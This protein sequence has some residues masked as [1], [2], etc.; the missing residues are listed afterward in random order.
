MQRAILRFCVLLIGTMLFVL[1]GAFSVA[2]QEPARMQQGAIASFAPVVEKV[3]PS[4][5]TV[6]TT[7]TVS[8]GLAPFPFSDDALRQ[9]FGG[10][11]PRQGKQ[12]L[13][14][15]G[16][17][18]IVSPDGYIL[19]ANH[20]VS[21]AEEIMVGLGTEL[22][23]YKAKK[24]GTDPGTDVALLK[25]DEKNLPAIA[26][27]DSEKARAGDI[28]LAIGNPFG[29][30][31]TVTMGIIS[32]VG[33][34]GMGIVDYENFIQTDAAINMGNSGGALVDT[35]G[36]L[37]GIN[38]A[39]FTRTG[40]S[41]GVGFA[42]PANLARDVM[43]SLREKGRVVR[44]Y[45]GTSV[46]TLTPELAEA[47]KLKGELTGALVGEVVPKSPSEKAGM[48]TGDVITSV[49]GKKVSDAR[50]LRLMIGSM[51]PGTKV[52]I[53]VNREGQKKMFDVELAEMPAGAAEQAPEAAPEESAQPEK[54]TVFGGVA[55]ADITDDIRSA[56]NLSK[57]IQGA[58]I[59]QIDAD[60]PAAKS[61]L[62]EGDVI[63]EVNKQPVK[64]AKDLVVISKKLKPTEKILMRVYSQGRSG[65]V[66]L[67]PK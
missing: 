12:T 18:V 27:A 6:F 5:V 50:E 17:G 25:I 7:Q 58:V 28:V 13:Q 40:G 65:Y 32:A 35:E 53:E 57:D 11:L 46:Q 34:G 20:V 42:I 30:R 33:R 24:V 10:Q 29:L 61:G 56:L 23:K 8:R 49:N 52:Q 64:N 26:F 2:A 38:T 37:L 60:S 63:Q 51:A 1:T 21:G 44:G 4:V 55:V 36:R 31:Q 3:A 22:R 15:L 41:Q 59:A 16:S 62:R 48:K 14:G 43:Q 45:I 39:I 66:A 9:F 54:T 47:M 19:T 67:E